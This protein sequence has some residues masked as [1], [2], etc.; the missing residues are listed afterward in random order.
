[1]GPIL[2]DY[3]R[4]GTTYQPHLEGLQ[5][6]R[7]NLLVP[8]WRIIDVSVQPIGPHLEGLP[9]FR[10]NLLVSS[11]RITDVSVQPIGP[12]F[13]GYRRF[14]TTG[15]QSTVRNIPEGRRSHLDRGRSVRYSITLLWRTAEVA[16]A[17]R[18]RP[19]LIWRTFQ[20]TGASQ[21]A[22]TLHAVPPPSCNVITNHSELNVPHRQTDRQTDCT[23]TCGSPQVFVCMLYAAY[24][25]QNMV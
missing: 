22:V 19:T 17:C 25:V 5:T 4:F 23:N 20:C 6:F 16:L 11:W 14:G 3:R 13:K 18:C 7:C 15:W 10:Y 8:Y 24:C 2:K 21:R 9:M 12:I 1:M